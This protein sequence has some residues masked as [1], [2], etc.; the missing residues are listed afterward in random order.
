M[1]MDEW[2]EERVV[3]PKQEWQR[4]SAQ[5]KLKKLHNKMSKRDIERE[6]RIE[7]LGGK[8]IEVMYG[9]PLSEEARKVRMELEWDLK[10]PQRKVKKIPAPRPS[11]GFKVRK[12]KSRSKKQFI[13]TVLAGAKARAKAKGIPF[14]LESSDVVIPNVC[15]VLGI[16]LFWGSKLTNNT[17]SIDRVVPEKGYVK[18]NCVVISM[19]ANR[20]KNNASREELEAILKYLSGHNT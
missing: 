11:R 12:G 2:Y 8:P 5:A 15:P 18:G 16:P 14:E 17:P 20:L 10:Y 6:V 1:D 13:H 19:K 3:K 7:N 9:I 4:V